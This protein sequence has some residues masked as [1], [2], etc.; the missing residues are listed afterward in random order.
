MKY[1]LLVLCMVLVGC[2]GMTDLYKR[3]DTHYKGA[4]VMGSEEWIAADRCT[5]V[6]RDCVVIVKGPLMLTRLSASLGCKNKM[7]LR[8]MNSFNSREFIPPFDIDNV[9]P[10]GL[11]YEVRWGEY[12]EVVT[13]GKLNLDKGCIISWK[14]YH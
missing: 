7:V 10:D 5:S 9:A 12:L 6:L 8:H 2:W 1:L 3:V 11:L 4:Y 13:V 14:G